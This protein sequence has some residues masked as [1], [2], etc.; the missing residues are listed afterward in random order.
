MG[1]YL[2]GCMCA[3][4]WF[5]IL[6]PGLHRFGSYATFPAEIDICEADNHKKV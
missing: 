6:R 5:T 3:L 4:D 2:L 1:T